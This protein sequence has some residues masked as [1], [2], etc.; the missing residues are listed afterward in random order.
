MKSCEKD[1]IWDVRDLYED[2]CVNLFNI[3]VLLKNGCPDLEKS[4][5]YQKY[6]APLPLVVMPLHGLD[7]TTQLMVNREKESSGYWDF[8]FT[9]NDVTDCSFSFI[10][11]FDFDKIG[12][13]ELEFYRVRIGCNDPSGVLAGRDALIRSNYAQIFMPDELIAEPGKAG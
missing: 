3:L 10:D 7:L 5:G 11:C 9:D 8:K 13:K 6:P 2:M 4:R 12:F 1:E